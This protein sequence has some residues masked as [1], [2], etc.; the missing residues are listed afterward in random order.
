MFC[1][2]YRC[3]IKL[4]PPMENTSAPKAARPIQETAISPGEYRASRST[5]L[6]TYLLLLFLLHPFLLDSALVYS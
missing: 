2:A 4:K 1:P 6:D 5:S 3:W